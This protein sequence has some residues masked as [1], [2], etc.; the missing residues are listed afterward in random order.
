MITYT[1]PDLITFLKAHNRLQT[2]NAVTYNIK[3]GLFNATATANDLST[4]INN[5]GNWRASREGHT[6]W[7]HT[8]KHLG[9]LINFLEGNQKKAAPPQSSFR[10][11]EA[12][13]SEFLRTTAADLSR[14][15]DEIIKRYY[16][17]KFRPIEGTV[18]NTSGFYT[19]TYGKSTAD[20]DS[21][22]IVDDRGSSPGNPR[23]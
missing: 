6:F 7:E 8:A 13:I 5:L 17:E 2:A 15:Q 10:P 14:G 3:H 21:P 9:N 1:V 18:E 23:Y 20:A 19:I 12:V 11:A 16:E 4:L 22:I